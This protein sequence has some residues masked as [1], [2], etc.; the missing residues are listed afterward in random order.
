MWNT[1]V[2]IF[3]GVTAQC[4]SW[5]DMFMREFDGAWGTI[6]TLITILVICRFLLSSI[7]GFTFSA[8]SDKVASSIRKKEQCIMQYMFYMIFTGLLVLIWLRLGD[9]NA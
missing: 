9:K 6:F 4:F 8:G 7:I 2:N 3:V 5:F 1:I